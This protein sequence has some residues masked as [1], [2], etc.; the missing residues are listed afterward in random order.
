MGDRIAGV[1]HP[2]ADLQ[3]GA[4]D[5][6]DP[7]V[8]DDV[9]G[10][11]DHVA[12]HDIVDGCGHHPR[13]RIGAMDVVQRGLLRQPGGSPVWRRGPFTCATPSKIG[14]SLQRRIG[15]IH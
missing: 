6:V 10:D 5:V 3:G 1:F 9:P 11:V 4:P 12:H 13:I 15:V 2:D 7:G 14:T 8:K